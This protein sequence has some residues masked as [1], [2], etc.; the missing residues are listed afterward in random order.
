MN[1]KL[2]K[3]FK[4]SWFIVWKDDSLK[5]WIISLIFLFIIIKLIFFPLLNL[6]TGTTLPLVI[7]ESCSMYHEGNLFSD[8]D[9]WQ[10]NHETKYRNYFLDINNFQKFP[11]KNGFNKGDILFVIGAKPEKLEVGDVVIFNANH[12]NPI[13]HRIIGIQEKNGEYTFST[14]GDNNNGQLPLEKEINENQIMGKAVL[15]PA[16]YLGWIKLIFFEAQR[17]DSER[18]FCKEN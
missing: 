17:T 14:I 15:K 5:G 18:G 13:I 1:D 11:F 3:F 2:K 16:P 12:K 10:T 8:F 6:L 4:K 9:N 7:V